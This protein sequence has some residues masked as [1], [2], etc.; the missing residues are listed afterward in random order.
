MK[1]SRLIALGVA[2]LAG[3]AGGIPTLGIWFSPSDGLINTSIIV[4]IIL[5][6]SATILAIASSVN[7]MLINPKGLQ[8]AAIGIG[9]LLFIFLLSYMLADGSD[10]MIYDNV[11]ESTT[12]WVATGLNAFYIAFTLAIASVIYSSLSRLRK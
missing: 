11:D 7:G 12:K 8:G 4:T 5:I 1:N 9:G 2:G 6:I 10:Y 3:L